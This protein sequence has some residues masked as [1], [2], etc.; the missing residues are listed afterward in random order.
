MCSLD[1]H[2]S[3]LEVQS[4]PAYKVIHSILATGKDIKLETSVVCPILMD[5]DLN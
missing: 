3:H 1:I 4:N 2:S 5:Y